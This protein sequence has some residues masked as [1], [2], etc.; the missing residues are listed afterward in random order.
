M[1]GM[2]F[3]EQTQI[4]SVIKDPI[5]LWQTDT[6][7]STDGSDG[8]LITRNNI[9]DYMSMFHFF[10]RYVRELGVIT[11]EE[12]VC[13]ATSRPAEFYRLENR[14]ILLPGF[15]ADVNVFDLNELKI[16]A[17]FSNP[18]Q[19]C[20]GMDYVIVNGTPVIAKGEHTKARAGRVL[21]H[22]PKK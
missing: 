21:R 17:T 11:M 6:R 9:Q 4:D 20:T 13:K 3:H 22:L 5:Y 18:R 1:Q 8:P 15:Y 19:Y 7:V 2:V 12:A 10:I 16:N 14:G